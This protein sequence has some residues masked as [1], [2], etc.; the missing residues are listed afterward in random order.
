[1]GFCD[2][3]EFSKVARFASRLPISKPHYLYG[4]VRLR[5]VNTYE[6]VADDQ[7]LLVT[8]ISHVDGTHQL[9]DALVTG[10]PSFLR[11]EVG[12]FGAGCIVPD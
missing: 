4:K 7:F 8:R 9:F 11:Q 1:M 12:E 10:F 5:V 6:Y 3:N 2:K